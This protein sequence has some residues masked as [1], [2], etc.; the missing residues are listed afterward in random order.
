M[1]QNQSI[2][3]HDG[4]TL[5]PMA[6]FNKDNCIALVTAMLE[7]QKQ[8]VLHYVRNNESLGSGKFKHTYRFFIINDGNVFNVSGAITAA[9]GAEVNDRSMLYSINTMAPEDDLKAF[10]DAIRKFTGMTDLA[11]KDLVE[12]AKEVLIF[13]ISP[14]VFEFFPVV[15]LPYPDRDS[16]ST[17]QPPT[18]LPS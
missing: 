17:K 9:F 16:N 11:L 7:A 3:N 15:P 4:L 18:A 12:G 13:Q 6:K 10:S 14:E 2:I 8:P 5:H 1:P